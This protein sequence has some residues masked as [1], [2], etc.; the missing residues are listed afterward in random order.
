MA[1]VVANG[2]IRILPKIISP[3]QTGFVKGR[4]I[5]E[6]LVTYWESLEWAKV[7]GQNEAMLLIYFEKAYGRIEW[8]F[9][10]QMLASLGFP[11]SF[12]KIVQTLL[13]DAYAVVDANGLKSGNITLSKSIR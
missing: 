3:T 9:I 7:F 11:E 5:L 12:C 6:N 2:M 8:G 1:K 13:S 10:N 4:Y